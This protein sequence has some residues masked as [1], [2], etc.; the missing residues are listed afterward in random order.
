MDETA[1]GTADGTTVDETR[2]WREGDCVRVMRPSSTAHGSVGLVVSSSPTLIKVQLGSE[3]RTF[4]AS[5]LR[6][7]GQGD[8]IGQG[9]EKKAVA[10][11]AKA[12]EEQ[13]VIINDGRRTQNLTIVFKKLKVDFRTW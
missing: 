8:E 5:D 9:D 11:P 4:R 13:V 2:T 12:K 1:D 10:K 7:A 3:V 6:E